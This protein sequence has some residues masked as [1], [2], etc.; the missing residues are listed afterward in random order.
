MLRII[1]LLWVL[2]AGSASGQMLD[3]LQAT[4]P[5]RALELRQRAIEA[6]WGGKAMHTPTP[7]IWPVA[8]NVDALFGRH[9]DTQNWIQ[10]NW[11]TG[12]PYGIRARALFATFAGSTCLMV[13][14]GGHGV[15]FA[16]GP[17]PASPGVLQFIQR[18]AAANCDIVLISMPMDGDNDIFRDGASVPHTNADGSYHSPH[19]DF[20]TVPSLQLPVGMGLRIF[21][22][23]VIG[24]IDYA[25][26]QRSYTLTAMSGLSGGG[27]TTTVVAA[28]D[29]RIQRSYAVAG[30][31]PILQRT[32]DVGDIEQ[33][34]PAIY[35]G[36][37]Y[38]DLYLMAVADPGRRA[39]VLHND[40][41]SCCFQGER[42]RLYAPEL[43][44]YAAQN[45]FGPISWHYTPAGPAGHDIFEAHQ[46]TILDDLL[47]P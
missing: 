14:H 37:D 8:Q 28:L 15:A 42:V 22:E 38:H 36:I 41:D 20:F 13:H 1:A 39:M 40:N 26:A 21:L 7:I 25:L 44:D 4:T 3:T 47:A 2:T 33:Q 16:D 19:D 27:W 45:G 6:I 34:L 29:P 12:E 18:L 43:E 23:P 32:N 9:P 11:A 5:A 31:T 30:S 17:Y 24:A 46:N 35:P 10:F